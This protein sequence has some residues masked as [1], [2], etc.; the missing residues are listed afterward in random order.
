MRLQYLNSS[1]LENERGNLSDLNPGEIFSWHSSSM[2]SGSE[3]E[4]RL[5]SGMSMP[6]NPLGHTSSRGRESLEGSDSRSTLGARTNANEKIVLDY[7]IPPLPVSSHL[8]LWRKL[9]QYEY[10]STTCILS[11][12][13]IECFHILDLVYKD[14]CAFL[15]RFLRTYVSSQK[16]DSETMEVDVDLSASE[17]SPD[18]VEEESPESFTQNQASL[19]Y[20]DSILE[21][22]RYTSWL[23]A[24]A[25]RFEV[26]VEPGISCVF[27]DIVKKCLLVRD[28][29]SDVD[30]D[31]GVLIGLLNMCITIGGKC[32]GQL[33]FEE[34]VRF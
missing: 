15:T 4:N 24:L 17:E 10:P 32:F 23:F 18:W 34:L 13:Q 21:L 28:R 8:S 29:L 14:L 11:L 12:S 20:K 5:P 9:I 7:Q 33:S 30:S 26:P 2:V 31:D 22:E 27:R 6:R 16:I 3:H 19:P 1:S 25:V